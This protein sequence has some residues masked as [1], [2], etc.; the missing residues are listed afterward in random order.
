M[1]GFAR[2]LTSALRN[3][4]RR[5]IS[6]ALAGVAGLSNASPRL[7]KLAGRCLDG[8]PRLKRRIKQALA[9]SRAH[10]PDALRDAAPGEAE[11][12]L[13]RRTREVLRDLAREREHASRDGDSS[14]GGR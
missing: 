4:G 5:G 9:A 12:V 7:W 13:S 2:D 11:R 10:R 3:A 8:A 14:L 6:R 1:P